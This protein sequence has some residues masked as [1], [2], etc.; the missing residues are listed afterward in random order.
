MDPVI[1]HVHCSDVADPDAF[2]N[3]LGNPGPVRA[4]L[5]ETMRFHCQSLQICEPDRAFAMA[6]TGSLRLAAPP[7]SDSRVVA[8]TRPCC[9][10]IR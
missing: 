8:V 7:P 6:R 3:V 1:A 4:T 5:T 9:G 2:N 10:L